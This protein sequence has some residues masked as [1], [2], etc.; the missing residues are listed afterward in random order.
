M[1]GSKVDYFFSGA[2][3][4]WLI[5]VDLYLLNNAYNT[6]IVLLRSP[7]TTSVKG[8]QVNKLCLTT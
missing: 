1:C 8:K 2:G 6:L 3:S 5:T 7:C 4:D